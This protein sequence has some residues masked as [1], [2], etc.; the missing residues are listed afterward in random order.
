MIV[1]HIGIRSYVEANYISPIRETWVWLVQDFK[2]GQLANGRCLGREVKWQDKDLYACHIERV[3]YWCKGCVEFL[4]SPTAAE[5]PFCGE[6]QGVA[7]EEIKG[8]E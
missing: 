1:S 3:G 4:A 6:E 8:E 5:C 2:T 7:R